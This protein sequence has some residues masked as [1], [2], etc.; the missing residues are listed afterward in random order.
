M[1]PIISSELTLFAQE[2]QRF[3]SPIVL[4]ENAKQVGFVQR[5]SK[6]Q[7]AELIALC[8]WLSQEVA[9]TSLTQLCSR[10]EASTGVLISP[11]GLN[12]RFNPAAVAFL[13]EVFTSLL[14]QKLCLNQSLFSDTISVLER[15]R[16]LDATVF[17]LPDSFATN[18][19]G[20]GGSSNTAGVKIQLE[21]DLL[22]GQFLNV[23]LG[24]GKNNDK[25]YGTT[26][27]GTVEKGDLCLRD[28]GYFDLGDLQAIH[29][30]E[31]YYISRL[32]LNTRIYIK[33]PHPEF[34]NNGIIK[35]QTEYIQVDMTQMMSSLTP[36]ETLEIPEAYIGQNQ[37]LQARVIIHRLTD[38]QTQTRLK[39][40]AIREK[41]KGNVMK[42]KSKHLVGMNVYIT[43]TSPEEVP[44][45]YV[46]SLYSL[47]WQI[48]ILFKTWKSF[49]EIDEC[50]TIKKERLECHLY[51]QLI[52]IL[53]CSST[54][55][56]MRQL[57]HEK[58]K[59][60]LSEYKA[61]YMIKDYFPLLFQAMTFG[62][63]EL[64]KILHRLFH[65]L[66]KNG[67][68]CHR[69]KKMTVFDI[70]GV[71]YETTVKHKQAA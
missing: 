1:N 71:V 24:P 67:R 22:S 31:A 52:G 69:Y 56:Q 29:V 58:K 49:F 9:S 59:K 32:K 64:L 27:L 35:K 45:D 50:K 54:M 47:R 16:I 36:S 19:Q 23:Q 33:N 61:I 14:K 60:E 53:L 38:D 18:Y 2:L 66:K 43:N 21:Y 42:D 28:L 39:N 70:L 65:L 34:F 6:Y 10:L 3:L 4:Q 11:E 55:F 63:E 62:K 8:V 30:K 46:H 41:K 48:E 15:I 51:G 25:T 5:S 17:Q 44:T 7:A 68:K 13:R 57:I 26:C 37:K 12:Q 20:S 40:Q